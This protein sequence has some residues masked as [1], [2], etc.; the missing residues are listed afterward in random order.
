MAFAT[1]RG[2]QSLAFGTPRTRQSVAFAFDINANTP[3]GRQSLAG[4]PRTRQSTGTKRGRRAS[5]SSSDYEDRTGTG[6]KRARLST[7]TKGRRSSVGGGLKPVSKMT[8]AEVHTSFSSMCRY[9]E[10]KTRFFSCYRNSGL[11]T[12]I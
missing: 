9:T 12:L 7:A 3:R 6:R 5:G 10:L 11:R 1:P 4:T 8:K 2:R